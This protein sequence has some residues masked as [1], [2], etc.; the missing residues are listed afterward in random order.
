M[1]GREASLVGYLASKKIY[2]YDKPPFIFFVCVSREKKHAFAFH[3]VLLVLTF[4]C[5]GV[6][7]D[8]ND[9]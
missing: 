7:T 4:F 1:A 6:L 8:E 9:K 2:V 3:F 5:K